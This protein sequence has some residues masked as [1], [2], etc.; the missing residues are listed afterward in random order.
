[1][2]HLRLLSLLL[3]LSRSDIILRR[4]FYLYNENASS[5]L[6]GRQVVF[7]TVLEG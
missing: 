6:D 7:G 3:L 5:H 1:M 2:E 4:I